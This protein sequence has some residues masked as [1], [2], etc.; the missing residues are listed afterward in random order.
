MS[1]IKVSV[2]VPVYNCENFLAECL[3]SL[4]NQTLKDIE[5]ILIDDGSED[6]S[7]KICDKYAELDSRVKV[8]HKVNE[9]QGIARNIGIEIAKGEYI[10]FVDSDDWVDS[11]FYEKLY[12]NAIKYSAD[13]SIGNIVKKFRKKMTPYGCS[14]YQNGNNYLFEKPED[15]KSLVYLNLFVD[16]IVKKELFVKNN[17]KFIENKIFEDTPVGILIAICSNRVIYRSDYYYYYRQDNPHSTM[18]TCSEKTFLIFDIFEN[19]SSSVKNLDISS[20]EKNLYNE[21]IFLRNVRQLF[22]FLFITRKDLKEK[23]LKLS[24]EYLKTVVI[25]KK[26]LYTIDIYARGL[27]IKIAQNA[28]LFMVCAYLYYFLY[29]ILTPCFEQ[30]LKNFSNLRQNKEQLK[31]GEG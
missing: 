21:M 10:G 25:D 31:R 27:I 22:Y 9:G 3:N 30:P 18:H 1:S 11:E 7:G 2:I 5:I 26:E 8:I 19:I 29:K 20:E 16:K 24:K 17:I 12:E 15:K 6:N 13:V 4:C 23:F 28:F 14:R